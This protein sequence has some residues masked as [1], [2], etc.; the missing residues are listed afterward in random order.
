MEDLARPLRIIPSS[1]P[2]VRWLRKL[3]LQFSPG[4]ELNLLLRARPEGD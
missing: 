4:S 1:V 3:G 2:A